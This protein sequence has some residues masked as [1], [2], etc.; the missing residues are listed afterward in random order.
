MR[1]PNRENGSPANGKYGWVF[2]L[3]SAMH[4]DGY[5][6]LKNANGVSSSSPG[7]RGTSY[8]GVPTTAEPTLKGLNQFSGPP[9]Q[10]FQVWRFI[11]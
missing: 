8:P 4:F 5:G 2:D 6:R 7:L 10:P 3:K 1:Q 9:I 11:F